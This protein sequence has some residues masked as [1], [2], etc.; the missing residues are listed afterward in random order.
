MFFVKSLDSEEDKIL[1]EESL[2]SLQKLNFLR[3]RRLFHIQPFLP[4]MLL[5]CPVSGRP[6]T[7]T[8]SSHP[9]LINNSYGQ[10]EYDLFSLYM[11]ILCTVGLR[12]DDDRPALVSSLHNV[13]CQLNKLLVLPTAKPCSVSATSFPF[14]LVPSEKPYFQV[15]SPSLPKAFAA[16]LLAVSAGPISLPLQPPPLSSL[17]MPLSCQGASCLHIC[18][19][20]HP[21]CVRLKLTL[22]LVQFFLPI[23]HPPLLPQLRLIC[24]INPFNPDKF[25]VWFLLLH[26]IPASCFTLSACKTIPIPTNVEITI[27]FS[28]GACQMPWVV[29]HKNKLYSTIQHTA[30]L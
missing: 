13:L 20:D 1:F 17:E 15:G 14:A 29:L 8:K 23:T 30:D 16:F 9:L 10:E 24:Q 6:C 4:D 12:A 22:K 2:Y 19:E 27:S 18:L 21:V 26:S 3:L 28:P 25:Q 11:L 7:Q 5:S